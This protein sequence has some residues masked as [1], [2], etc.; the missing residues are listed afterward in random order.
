MVN[1]CPQRFQ[2]EECDDRELSN[3]QTYWTH[4]E[5]RSQPDL[6]CFNSRSECILENLEEMQTGILAPNVTESN[7]KIRHPTK[8]KW[9]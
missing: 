1:G 4:E 7:I 9:K 3:L 8:R 2:T 5:I 6:M